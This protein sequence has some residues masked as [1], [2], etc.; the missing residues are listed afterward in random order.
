MDALDRVYRHRLGGRAVLALAVGAVMAGSVLLSL[1]NPAIA[2]PPNQLLNPNV[3]PS[4][5]TTKATFMFAVTYKSAEGNEPSSVSAVVGSTVIPLALEAGSPANG[6]YGGSAK[7]P[8][9][10]W[11]VIFRASAEH[12]NDPSLSGPTIRVRR[13]SQP[14][15]SPA[16]TP[17]AAPQTTEP[18]TPQPN[19]DEPTRRP[20]PSPEASPGETQPVSAGIVTPSPRATAGAALGGGGAGLSPLMTLVAGALIAL[21]VLALVGLFA[22][23]AA[24]RRRRRDERPMPLPVNARETPASA[25]REAALARRPAPWERDWALDDAHVRIVKKEPPLAGK[26]P[27]DEEG[28]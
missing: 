26:P 10:T 7:L 27:Q 5:A 24:R 21:A 4:D 23:L 28:A 1:R 2:A 9:G 12:R 8:A 19:R 15:P 14:L 20:Q 18:R 3:W 6:R 11:K 16:A 17:R 22:F 25:A 13:A